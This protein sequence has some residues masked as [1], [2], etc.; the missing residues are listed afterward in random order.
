MRVRTGRQQSVASRGSSPAGP[1]KPSCPGAEDS[2]PRRRGGWPGPAGSWGFSKPS[3]VVHALGL[4][5]GPCVC[6][7]VCVCAQSLSHDQ[8]SAIL[9][10]VAHQA[11]PSMG[12]SGQKY[13]SGFPCPPSRG[14]PEPGIKPMSLMSPALANGFFTT[15]ATW[16]AP[17]R[18]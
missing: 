2:Q 12:I 9:W 10:A 13:W 15:G 4:S 17:F 1:L 18:P 11:P 5:F 14:L 3:G 7:C 16:E 8:F 6:E